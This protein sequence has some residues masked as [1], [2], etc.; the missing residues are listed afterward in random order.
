ML[1]KP[2]IYGLMLGIPWKN[3]PLRDEGLNAHSRAIG[4]IGAPGVVADPIVRNGSTYGDVHQL[5]IG[6]PPVGGSIHMGFPW[7]FGVPQASFR[8]FLSKSHRSK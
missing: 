1:N 7:L 3:Q 5:L 4:A 2:A 6:D 8:W